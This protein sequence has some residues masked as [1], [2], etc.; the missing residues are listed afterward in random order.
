[1][2]SEGGSSMRRGLVKQVLSGDSV[3]I[4]GPPRPNGPPE[5]ATVY[6]ANTS[7]PRIGK[8]PTET[9]PGTADEPFAWEAREYLRKKLV[10]QVVTFIKEF[11]ATSSRDHGKVYLGGTSVDTAENVNESAVA[12][13]WLEV[14]QGKVADEYV[15][16]LLD[17]QEKAKAAKIGR[18]NDNLDGAVRDVKWTFTDPRSLVD[19][20][21][22]KPVDAVIEQV[23]DGSTVRAFL[24][25]RFEYITLQL[26]GVRSPSTRAGSDGAVE[27][28]SNEAKFF[29]ESRIL[30]QDVQIVLESVSNNNFVG[31]V[32]HPKGNIAE[33]LLREG[34][35]KCVDWSI[36]LCTGGAE[37][38]RAAETLAKNNRK[39]IWASYKPSAGALAEKKKFEAKVIEIVLNDSMIIARDNGEESKV[40]LSSVRLPREQGDRPAT[41]GRQFRPLYD[42]PYMYE[43]REYLRRK[44]IGKKVNVTVDYFQPKSDQFPE[45]TCCTI[46][47]NGQNVAIGLLERGLSKVV[48]HRNDDENRST[49][50]DA[51]LAAEAKAEKEQ[52]GLFAVPSKEEGN[53]TQRVQELQ[54]DLARSKQFLPYLQRGARSEGIVEFLTSG[55]RMRI[56]VPKETCL[57]TFLLGGINCPRSGR[58]AGANGQPAT[59]S[60]P[61]ADDAFRFTRKLVMHREVELEV[62]GLDK[63]GAFIGYLWVKPED[64]GRAQNLSELLL[65]QGLAT[66]HFT[67]EKSSHY[68]HMSAAE[69]RAK[70]AK[71]NIW[72]TWTDTD[73]EAKEEEAANQ[74][75]ERTVNYKKVAVSDVGKVGQSFRISAQSIEDGPKLEKLMG[76]LRVGIANSAAPS[77]VTVKRGE[78]VA[79]KF[80]ADKQW[81]RAK[82]ESVKAGMA[83]V[84]Y[85]DFGNRETISTSDIASLPGTLSS[86]A[87]SAKDYY[88]ALTA[89]PNDED[90]AGFAVDALQKLLGS[91]GTAEINVEYSLAGAQYAQVMVEINGERIDVGKA[92]IED[93]FALAE[94]RREERLQKMVASY[95]EAEKL[96]RKQRS[97]IWEFGD[98]TG[99][100]I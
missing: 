12:E 21:K 4:M 100:E 74:K 76:D 58:A 32:L 23:R 99:N 47:A 35:A 55:S 46:E 13:G 45:K 52:K 57:L 3:V 48:R 20:Y 37:N 25:P 36:G 78:M 89:V 5:E 9:T 64:G 84:L 15:T 94:K 68:N 97:N 69:T 33:A 59:V 17:L 71:R 26:S 72:S 91:A 79:A 43:C 31:S 61:Y 18:W 42:I 95:A 77:N 82:V 8:R 1:M 22:Q 93:G 83:D 27:P 96:A 50:Y 16:K 11:T 62:E 73:A 81:Y 86:I 90:Y 56:Y 51:L 49:H 98:F 40:Y 44:L 29:A 66:L 7:A 34:F 87:P 39:R 54:G 53:H 19:F 67:A 24:L 30:Q 75:S 65:E 6:L 85:V 38:L 10:G 88:L 60:E 2:A 28:F 92:L 80:S 63:Q 14:R 70:N 41:S